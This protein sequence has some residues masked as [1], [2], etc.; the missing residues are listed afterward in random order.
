LA[1]SRPDQRLETIT[2]S[3][4]QIELQPLSDAEMDELVAGAVDGAPATLLAAIRADG[5]GIPLY[6]VETLRALAD[7]GVLSIEGSRYVVREAFGEVSM[8]PTIR[9]LVSSRL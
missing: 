3:D 5:G 7:R 6:A 2:D 1:L 8:P 4:E 9:A